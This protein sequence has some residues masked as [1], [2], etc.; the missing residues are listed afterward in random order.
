MKIRTLERFSAILGTVLCAILFIVACIAKEMTMKDAAFF[1]VL[2]A[3]FGYG[4]S[5]LRDSKR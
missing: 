4:L 3:G 2:G 5:R 1:A